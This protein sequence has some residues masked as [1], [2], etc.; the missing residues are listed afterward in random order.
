[1]GII[2]GNN[3]Y[4]GTISFYSKGWG[5]DNSVSDTYL[6][7]WGGS[8]LSHT[9]NGND[10][11]PKWVGLDLWGPGTGTVEVPEPATFVLMGLGLLGLGLS[12][13]KQEV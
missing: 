4:D 5:Y 11:W 10:K 9:K 7:L 6:N 1:M 8:W 12:R 13:K 2:R 3:F